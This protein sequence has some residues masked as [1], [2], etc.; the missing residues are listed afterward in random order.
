MEPCLLKTYGLHFSKHVTQTRTDRFFFFCLV[1]N[2]LFPAGMRCQ[3][4]SSILLQVQGSEFKSAFTLTAKVSYQT[5]SKKVPC[6]SD[7]AGQKWWGWCVSCEIVYARC[8]VL[9][10]HSPC[11]NGVI[12]L[13]GKEGLKRNI[14]YSLQVEMG[15]IYIPQSHLWP[16]EEQTC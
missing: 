1:C 2:L 9:Y 10:G 7:W 11:H 5:V 13:T 16:S 15:F 3:S 4:N 12:N 14:I 6:C 8:G